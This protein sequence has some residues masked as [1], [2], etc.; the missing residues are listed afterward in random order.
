MIELLEGQLDKFYTKTKSKPGK[1]VISHDVANHILDISQSLSRSPGHVTLIGYSGSG[2][3]T[4]AKLSASLLDYE[5]HQ[6]AIH[7]SISIF[8][9]QTQLS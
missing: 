3:Q 6:V 9:N 7:S 1:W 8:Y 2:R 5:I 4:C